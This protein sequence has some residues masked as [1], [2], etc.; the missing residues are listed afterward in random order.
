MV[1]I[2]L[3]DDHAMFRKGLKRMIEDTPDLQVA[4]EAATGEEALAVLTVKLF[5]LV[6]MD[7]SM[8]GHNGL[9][10]L[11]DIKERNLAIP[12]LLLSMH[13]EDQFAIRSLRAG[14]SGY[15]TKNSEPDELIR[16]IRLVMKGKKYISQTLSESLVNSTDIKDGQLLHADLSDR[17]YQVFCLIANGKTVGTI[18]QE[19]RLSPQT[20]STYRKRTLQK[21]GLKTNAELIHYAI[22]NGLV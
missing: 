15:L 18:A 16:A 20:V 3:V 2:L 10:V 17:E 9:D 12:V 1:R 22:S 5:D 21:M 11:K 6:L 19:M 7:I 14:A 8:P 4:A 13:S